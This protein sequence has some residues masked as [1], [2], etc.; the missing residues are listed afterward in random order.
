MNK[1]LQCLLVAACLSLAAGDVAAQINLRSDATV[2]QFCSDADDSTFPRKSALEHFVL[3]DDFSAFDSVRLR[4]G[5]SPDALDPDGRGTISARVKLLRA[6]GSMRKLGKLTAVQNRVSGATASIKVLDEPLNTG[7]VLLWS[8]KFK[9]F[10]SLDDGQC[11]V[12]RGA[13]DPPTESCGPYP[14]Q[15]TSEYILPYNPGETSVISQGNCTHGSHKNIFRYAYDFPMPVGT[16]ILAVRAGTVV[17]IEDFHPDDTF[18][19]VDDNHL[20][21]EHDDGSHSRYVH[22]TQ[23][24]ALVAVG[25]RVEQGQPIALSGNSGATSGLPHLHF[26]V[27]PCANRFACGT[28]PITFRNTRAHPRGLQLGR[29]YTAR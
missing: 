28:S 16:E 18:Q 19:G 4:L 8:F 7:D 29:A 13:V 12:A 14:N 5:Y 27:Y 17:D 11:F 25:D 2:Q 26:L 21:I 1:T 20:D 9:N 6:D 24:G 23:N 10:G 3:V 22:I 15:D